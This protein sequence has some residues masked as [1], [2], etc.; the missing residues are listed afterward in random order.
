[1]K[2]MVILVCLVFCLGCSSSSLKDRYPFKP[3][4][5]IDSETGG[6]INVE[7]E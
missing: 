7:Q 2:A 5:I 6:P 1:M 3:S 4:V